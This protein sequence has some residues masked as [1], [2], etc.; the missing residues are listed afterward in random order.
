MIKNL[1]L[2]IISGD[3]K[4]ATEIAE[5]ILSDYPENVDALNVMAAQAYIE[6]NFDG[7]MNISKR[8]LDM[9]PKNRVASRAVNVCNVMSELSSSRSLEE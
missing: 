4:K 1:R 5:N 9:D 6:K 8:V 3:I 7:C 2:A